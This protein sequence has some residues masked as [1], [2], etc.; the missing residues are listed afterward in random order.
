MA[1]AENMPKDNIE[2]AI[3]KGSGELEGGAAYE[4][5]VYEGYGPRR[6]GRPR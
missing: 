6:G 2:K 1:K 5:I 3:K 4:E